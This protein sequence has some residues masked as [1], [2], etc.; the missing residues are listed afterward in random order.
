MIKFFFI[1]FRIDSIAYIFNHFSVVH[2]LFISLSVITVSGVNQGT[3][4]WRTRRLTIGACLCATVR[5]KSLKE[6]YASGRFCY[7]SWFQK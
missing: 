2:C 5:N 1:H 4:L 7:V 6:S 3:D